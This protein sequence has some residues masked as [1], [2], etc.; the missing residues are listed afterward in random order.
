[1]SEHSEPLLPQGWFW[2]SHDDQARLFAEY[3][4]ELPSV[5]PLADVPVQVLAHREGNDDIL[6]RCSDR[7]DHVAV[8]HLSWTGREELA[9][10]PTLEYSGSFAGFVTWELETYGV[11][12]SCSNGP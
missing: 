10:H 5:H 4:R 1:M 2:S 6:V 3:T 11:G 9:N 12:L 8:V 7:Q